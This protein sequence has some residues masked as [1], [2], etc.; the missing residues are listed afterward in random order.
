[1]CQWSDADRA[2]QLHNLSCQTCRA[3]GVNPNFGQR[4]DAGQ[5]LWTAYIE[6]GDPPHIQWSSRTA[7]VQPPQPREEKRI[8]YGAGPRK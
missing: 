6:A 2:Y 5:T 4:C 8:T 1:M 3:A 7:R